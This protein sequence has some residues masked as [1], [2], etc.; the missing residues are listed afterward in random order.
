M[1]PI[2][3]YADLTPAPQD[4][5]D[6][7]ANF[8]AQVV[9][10]DKVLQSP[11]TAAR[12]QGEFEESREL[13]HEEIW[14]DSA[15]IEAWNSATEEFEALNGP[16]KSWKEVPTHRSPLWYNVPPLKKPRSGNA[17]V[18]SQPIDFDTYVPSHNPDLASSLEPLQTITRAPSLRGV[19]RDEAFSHAMNAMYWTGYWTAIYHAS[20]ATSHDE[21]LIFFRSLVIKKRWWM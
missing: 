12:S 7:T 16:D 20:D 11:S 18:D 19:G 15:L 4:L 17:E 10:N 13:T 21:K 3:S 9:T 8:N 5:E 1:R 6:V 2:V 14:D